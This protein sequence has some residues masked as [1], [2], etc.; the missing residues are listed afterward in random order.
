MP[1]ITDISLEINGSVLLL[2]ALFVAGMTSVFIM[3]RSTVPPIPTWRKWMLAIVR[4]SALVSII[5][6]LF[7][8]LLFVSIEQKNT[9]RLSILVDNSS[10]MNITDRNGSITAPARQRGL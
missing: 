6:M 10:S 5:G 3:Y 9:P 8:P 1:V 4:V 2:I 7:T